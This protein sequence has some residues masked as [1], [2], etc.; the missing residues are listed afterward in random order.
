VIGNDGYECV[1]QSGWTGS[2]CD[3]DIDE[4]E[5]DPCLNE[6]VCIDQIGDFQCQCKSG[7]TGKTCLLG[8]SKIKKK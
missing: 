3:I 4:C 2:N 1:C 8:K 6:G 5:N 7:W